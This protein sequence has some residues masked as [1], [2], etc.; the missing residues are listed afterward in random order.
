MQFFPSYVVHLLIVTFLSC[1][2][3]CQTNAVVTSSFNITSGIEYCSPQRKK[4]GHPACRCPCDSGLITITQQLSGASQC[5]T[6][7]SAEPT[8]SAWRQPGC[9]GND[10][11]YDGIS[12][13][14]I[15]LAALPTSSSLSS[16]KSSCMGQYSSETLGECQKYRKG[17]SVT[18]YPWE[19][20]KPFSGSSCVPSPQI[21]TDGEFCLRTTRKPETCKELLVSLCGEFKPCSAAKSGMYTMKRPDGKPGPDGTGFFTTYCDMV[22]SGGGWMLLA[23]S[24]RDRGQSDR[25]KFQK[26]T[27]SDYSEEGFGDPDDRVSGVY[28]APLKWWKTLTDLYPEN[29]VAFF[30][31]RFPDFDTAPS[32]KDFSLERIELGNNQPPTYRLQCGSH[33]NSDVFLYSC[34]SSTKQ[35]MKFTT[36]DSD[37][38]IW[39]QNCAK[40]QT[41]QSSGKG[42]GWFYT[43][44]CCIKI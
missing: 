30:D 36:F 33:H 32:I 9:P 12:D 37:N 14:G 15:C 29:D 19:T 17:Q 22:T 34:G 41:G 16:V 8:L 23:K 35:G 1:H 24:M 11:P 2:L 31:N 42:T 28:W 13:Q 18:G 38:D 26:G 39:D 10:C 21:A 25:E 20:S 6:R 40:W 3:I 5:A 44:T 4:A 27:L 43:G 7:G